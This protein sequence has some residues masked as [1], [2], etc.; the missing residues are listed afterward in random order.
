MCI[1]DSLRGIQGQV[2]QI[3]PFLIFH[4]GAPPLP[5]SYTH[6]DVYKRQAMGWGFKPMASSWTDRRW[7]NVVLPDE[8]GPAIMTKRAFFLAAI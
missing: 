4:M 5:V 1:R 6:L 7:E 8:D 3:F 2:Q